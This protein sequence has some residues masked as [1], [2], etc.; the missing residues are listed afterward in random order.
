MILGMGKPVPA[1]WL[2]QDLGGLIPNSGHTSPL[3]LL[4]GATKLR[5]SCAVGHDHSITGIVRSGRDST[6]SSL[7]P[8]KCGPGWMQPGLPTNKTACLAATETPGLEPANLS[9][10]K[11]RCIE[12]Y[13]KQISLK[14]WLC[15][16]NIEAR[17]VWNV[18][19]CYGK[20]KNTLLLMP[21]AW[22]WP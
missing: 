1:L 4:A 12:K 11:E 14:I 16:K 9:F 20:N 21:Q 6:Q 18:L 7:G 2:E 5:Y 19:E 10:L 15:K 13:E 22:S 3:V 17:E 8:V